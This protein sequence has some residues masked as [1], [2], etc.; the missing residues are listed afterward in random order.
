MTSKFG[1]V[2]V[3]EPKQTNSR[4]GGMPVD[5]FKKSDVPTLDKPKEKEDR[6]LFDRAKDVVSSTGFGGLVG[7]ATPE[8]LTGAGMAL[9][10]GGFTAPAGPPLMMMGR[11]MRGQRLAAAGAGA[12]SGAAEEL[13]GQTAESMGASKPVEE[14]VRFTAGAVT[15][16]F[17]NLIK[18]LGTKAIKATGIATAGDVTGLINSINKDLG[19]S[20]KIL[21]PNQRK[22]IEK[23]ANDLRGG[24]V[25][26]DP[27]KIVYSA[28]ER[29]TEKIV[30]DFNVQ[31]SALEQ[32]ANA[33]VNA[34]KQ[35]GQEITQTTAQRLNNLQSQFESSANNLTNL[36]KQRAESVLKNSQ[37][38]ADQIRQRAAQSAPAAREIIEI[39]AREVIK[40]GRLQADQ[41]IKNA[42]DQVQRLRNVATKARQTGAARQETARESLA[43]I[44][45]PTTETK[46][47]ESIRNQILPRF[48][49]LRAVR[50]QNAKLNKQ[51]AFGFAYQ[52]E[53][54]GVSFDTTESYTRA[55]QEIEATKRNTPI[56]EAKNQLIKIEKLLDPRVVDENGVVISLQKPTFEGLELAR[57]FLRDRADG[58]PA[59]GYDAISQQ[60]AKSLADNIDRIMVEFSPS[61]AK[62]KKQY[63]L[64]SEPLN[65]FKN[66]IGKAVV[67]KEEFDMGRFATDPAAIG[68]DI[69]KTETGIKDL[70]VLM[71]GDVQGAE[72]I[73]R[74]FVADKLQNATAK[75]IEKFIFDSRDWLPQ[76]KNLQEQLQGV[77]KQLA[78]GESVGGKRQA[79][80]TALRTEA[81]AL[82]TKAQTKA[83]RVESDAEKQAAKLESQGLLAEAKAIRDAESQ[84]GKVVSSAESQAQQIGRDVEGQIS[85]SAKAVERQK[86]KLEQEA[87]QKIA[88]VQ[89]EAEKQAAKLTGEAGK[90][91]AKGESIKQQILGKSL[92]AARV[93]EI[94]LSK[95]KQLWKEV[96]PII[97]S[98]PQAKKAFVDAVKQTLA[99]EIEQSPRGIIKNWNLYIKDALEGSKILSTR[100]IDDI[101]RELEKINQTVEGSKALTL[102]QRLIIRGLTGEAARGLTSALNLTGI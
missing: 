91:S 4:F 38:Q 67:G 62:Y 8:L 52:K 80:S 24:T 10:M 57:R 37:S 51:D 64:D 85:T 47:G 30:N 72:N 11:A 23:I 29:G 82:P 78:T 69:F 13:A 41:I 65:Q 33:I 71:G 9:S 73:A 49:Q 21:T 46:T 90:L 81:T 58:L 86:T 31:S 27:A 26:Y 28:L 25:S 55:L 66:K 17:G 19:S 14:I 74:G 102:M 45:T 12:V 93:Q 89:T 2:A 83:A 63:E 79:L 32:Q 35:S 101:S 3:D 96:G 94:I 70:V 54:S 16:E 99:S 40:Q 59:E 95:D 60:E 92:D 36:A 18:Y 34:A 97:A 53:Q 76:F 15:P 98:D 42:N 75:D 84:A 56:P 5:D 1:G 6:S 48:E 7:A 39:D 88:G 43:T 68:R 61:F 100:Q 20:E 50:D 87:K 77:A 22:Y 44:G